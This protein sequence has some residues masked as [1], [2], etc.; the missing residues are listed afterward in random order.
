MNSHIARACDCGIHYTHVRVVTL[1]ERR[2]EGQF[3]A[4]AAH[5]VLRSFRVPAATG[6]A[7]NESAI[8]NDLNVTAC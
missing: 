1:P 2:R 5:N 7:V 4:F 8:L 6:L 3:H